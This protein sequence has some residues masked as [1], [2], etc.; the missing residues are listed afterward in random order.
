M[1]TYVH[2]FH[3]LVSH[4]FHL[5]Y[6]YHIIGK[7][8]VDKHSIKMLYLLPTSTNIYTMGKYCT[9]ALYNNGSRDRSLQYQVNALLFK[10]QGLHKSDYCKSVV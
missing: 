5:Q 1:A 3:V 7:N 8:V 4:N 9:S 2:Q 6:T 10:N